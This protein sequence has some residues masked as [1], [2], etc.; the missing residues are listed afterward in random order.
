MFFL[1]EGH[2]WSTVA[3]L[4]ADILG[5]EE[6]SSEQQAKTENHSETGGI[7]MNNG[8]TATTGGSDSQV[9]S[10]PV[11]TVS[12]AVISS[13]TKN[14][15]KKS[16]LSLDLGAVRLSRL[17]VSLFIQARRAVPLEGSNEDADSSRDSEEDSN[18]KMKEEK[19]DGTGETNVLIDKD[20]KGHM[21]KEN[22]EVEKAVGGDKNKKDEP[23]GDSMTLEEAILASHPDMK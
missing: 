11:L 13:S 4:E 18:E 14:D 16:E 7:S 8:S 3:E 19:N 5:G 17:L 1:S 10:A 21:K 20:R 2:R 23:R 12:T 22:E 15:F 9:P 6:E